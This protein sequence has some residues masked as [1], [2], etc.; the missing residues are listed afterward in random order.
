MNTSLFLVTLLA[1]ILTLAT[2]PLAPAQG[3]PAALREQLQQAIARGDVAGAV[4][5]YADDAVIDGPGVC[6]A[7]PCVGKAAIQ[8]DIERRVT[9]KNQPKTLSHYVSGNVLTTRFEV[10]SD[11]IRKAGAER[12]IV[13]LVYEVKD[14]KI[15]AERGP[16]YER[17]DP[18][19][20]RYAEWLRT[21]QP[22][23]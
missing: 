8:R 12:I 14:G 9:A 20:A 15:V 16:L 1:S 13:W 18:Q 3:D 17:T 7:A 2:P 4:A 11:V 5:L 23:Q 6:A 21:Q 19:T 22:S 10:S